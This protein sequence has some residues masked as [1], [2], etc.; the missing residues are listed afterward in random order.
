MQASAQNQTAMTDAER[1]AAIAA[2]R[3]LPPLLA[4]Q[5]GGLSEADLYTAYVPGEWTVAQN[6]HHLADV[7]INAYVRMKLMLTEDH[8]AIKPFD[9]D[10]WAQTP[11][12]S[13]APIDGS[14]AI[15]TGLHP[16]WALLLEAALDRD[17]SQ[18]TGQHLELGTVTLD[19]LVRY[20]SG[21]GLLH[22]D[23]I[24]RTLAAK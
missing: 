21:H 18:I 20:Y 16:R 4:E 13:T 2:I 10:D 24:N 23:Q 11:D 12:A 6:V 1:Q 3:A 17:W 7:H 5:V 14:L 15:L 19:E 9:Q 8:P 22:I